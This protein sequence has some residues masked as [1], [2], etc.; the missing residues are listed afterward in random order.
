MTK[1]DKI[2]FIED[3][4]NSSKEAMLKKIDKIPDNWD[5]HE[6]RWL[7]TE[8]FNKQINFLQ[9][10]KRSKRYKDYENFCL[11]NNL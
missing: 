4:Y 3:I 1:A 10:D 8:D 7:A 2:K 5:G 9:V 6:L 11:C